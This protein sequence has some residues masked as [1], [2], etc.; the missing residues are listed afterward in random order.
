MDQHLDFDVCLSLL[1]LICSTSFNDKTK[2]L[3]TPWKLGLIRKSK[4]LLWAWFVGL[5][6]YISPLSVFL[7][8]DYDCL[9]SFMFSWVDKITTGT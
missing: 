3:F 4:Y 2:S 9:K 8:P 6:R 5:A 7:K 1:Q